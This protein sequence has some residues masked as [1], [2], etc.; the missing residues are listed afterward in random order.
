MSLIPEKDDAMPEEIPLRPPA[1]GADRLPS[2]LFLLELELAARYPRQDITVFGQRHYG[3]GPRELAFVGVESSGPFAQ[4]SPEASA[5]RK[6]LRR[7]AGTLLEALG[8]QIGL[9]PG[10]DVY[11]VD[12]WREDLSAHERILRLEEFRKRLAL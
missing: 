4:R 12:P 5:R 9:T 7:E 10:R 8:Y 2:D 1:P 3:M 6:A 11:H